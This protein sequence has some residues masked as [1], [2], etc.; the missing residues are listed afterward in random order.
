MSL[1]V[2]V[3]PLALWLRWSRHVSGPGG[4]YGFV[5]AAAGRRVALVQAAIWTFS[6]LLYIVYTTTQ[7]VYELLPQVMPGEASWQTP[8]ALLIPLAIVGVMVAGRTAALLT[9]GLLAAGQVAFAAVLDGVAM[10]HLGLP[11]SSFGTGRAR[12]MSS[13]PAP[14]PR[15]S[16]SVPGCRCS[17]AAS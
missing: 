14:R 9:L 1:V 12:A 2:F 8:L 3:A 4:L 5:E 11:L 6:Y 10:G 15:C 17:S 13:S 7:I 16:T